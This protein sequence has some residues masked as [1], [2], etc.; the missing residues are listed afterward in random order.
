MTIRLRDTSIETTIHHLPQDT[1][2]LLFRPLNLTD[3]FTVERVCKLWRRLSHSDNENWFCAAKRQAIFLDRTLPIRPQ[4][5]KSFIPY[6]K[7][8]RRIFPN[9]PF[10]PKGVHPFIE[11]QMIDT[12][13]AEMDKSKVNPLELLSNWLRLLGTNLIHDCIAMIPVFVEARLLTVTEDLYFN[14]LKDEGYLRNFIEQAHD[15]R[16]RA[17][18]CIHALFMN[19]IQ[20]EDFQKPITSLQNIQK[21]VFLL[22][23]H[24]LHFVEKPSAEIVTYLCVRFSIIPLRLSWYQIAL[25]CHEKRAALTSAL[26]NLTGAAWEEA[27][28]Q[29]MLNEGVNVDIDLQYPAFIQNTLKKLPSEEFNLIVESLPDFTLNTG[30]IYTDFMDNQLLRDFRR[31]FLSLQSTKL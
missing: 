4:V 12:Q 8:A 13:I 30:N 16:D 18:A 10:A 7:A 29:F 24:I 28:K 26:K 23:A 3:L 20:H 2:P 15:F 22:I 21:P 9:L 27:F 19:E 25:K 17:D 5:R 6:C 14:L 31:S 11:K 1:I